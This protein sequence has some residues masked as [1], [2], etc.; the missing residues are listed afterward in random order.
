MYF[1]SKRA[2]AKLSP[3]ATKMNTPM[4]IRVME[5]VLTVPTAE[6]IV[7][8]SRRGLMFSVLMF[9]TSD[10]A[11]EPTIIN[12]NPMSCKKLEKQI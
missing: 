2:P 1:L 11:R 10:K 8:K 5:S 12:P 4:T 7:N 3:T 9:D 6:S